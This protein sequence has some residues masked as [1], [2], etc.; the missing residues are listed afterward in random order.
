MPHP[1][2]I[3]IGFQF[4]AVHENLT[5]DEIGVQHYDQTWG[6]N[7]LGHADT[8]GVARTPWQALEA[9]VLF[10]QVFLTALDQILHPRRDLAGFEVRR[11]VLIIL[12]RNPL[13]NA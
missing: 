11:N 7:D 10:M 3:G 1:T 12:R 13:P 4:A 5:M 8:A 2:R 9:H 6:L